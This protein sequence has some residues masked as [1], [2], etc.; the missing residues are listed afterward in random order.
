MD[1]FLPGD[2]GEFNPYPYAF[3]E[4]ASVA[5]LA[6]GIW[7]LSPESVLMEEYAS[8]RGNPGGER[9]SAGRVDLWCRLSLP[10]LPRSYVCEAKSLWPRLR[11]RKK[12]LGEL[13]ATI[14][15]AL[16]Q[17]HTYAEPA[18]HWPVALVFVTPRTGVKR[19]ISSPED[20]MQKFFHRLDEGTGELTRAGLR[21]DYYPG[22]ADMDHYSPGDVWFPGTSLLVAFASSPR[23]GTGTS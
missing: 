9:D 22:F 7:G 14:E 21:A 15:A 5:L 18:E 10:P 11:G 6:G 1:R 23:G 12:L 13:S 20:T 2:P 8:R 17:V 16:R 4:R 19:R 3:N